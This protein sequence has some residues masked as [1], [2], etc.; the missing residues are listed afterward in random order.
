M[1]AEPLLV[2]PKCNRPAL[3]R[4]VGAGSGMIFRGSGFYLTDY[5]NNNSNKKSKSEESSISKPS[6]PTSSPTSS[7]K[8]A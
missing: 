8:K 1:K 7:D 4:L 2:C 5:K 3:K 6:A